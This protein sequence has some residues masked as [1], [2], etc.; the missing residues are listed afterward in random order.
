MY[1]RVLC[2]S[3]GSGATKLKLYSYIGIGKYL[4]VG[5]NFS[6]RGVQGAQGP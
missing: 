3:H 1:Y 4:G 6:A 5:Q 2:K